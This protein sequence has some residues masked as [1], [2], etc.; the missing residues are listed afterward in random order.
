MKEPF[1]GRAKRED[2]NKVKQVLDFNRIIYELFGEDWVED[3][4]VNYPDIL[5]IHPLFFSLLH[6][7]EFPNELRVLKEKHQRYP[8]FVKKLKKDRDNFDSH[9]SNLD[10]FCELSKFNNTVDLE[11]PIPNSRKSSDV[12]VTINGGEY[13]GEVMT[14]NRPEHE[15]EF[16][17]LENEIRVRYNRENKTKN[18]VAV[19]FREDFKDICKEKFIKFLLDRAMSVE[20][21]EEETRVMQYRQDAKVLAEV[22]YFKKSDVFSRGYFGIGQSPLWW[23]NSVRRIRRLLANKIR[24]FQFPDDVKKKKFFYIYVRD[25]NIEPSDLDYALFGEINPDSFPNRSAKEEGDGN[26]SIYDNKLG[27]VLRK[28]DFVVYRISRVLRKVKFYRFNR[29]RYINEQT[30]KNNF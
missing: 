16:M 1:V 22:T 11:P 19:V 3:N 17:K 7:A 25:D 12:K 2:L 5:T 26:A 6:V 27:P 23:D 29:Q 20:L 13:W 4:I 8:S 21:N 24:K 18:C 14:I 28:I 30:I 15:Y 9:V 10:V